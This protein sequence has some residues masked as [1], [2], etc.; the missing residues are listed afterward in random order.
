MSGASAARASGRVTVLYDAFGEAPAL[1]KDWGFAALVE[2]GGERILFDTGNDADIFAH[3]VS[4]LGVELSTIDLVVIS[5]RH[6][7]HTSG[8]NHLLRVNHRVKI[9]APREGF[10]VFGA[11]L[12]G[13]FY[14]QDASLPRR[15]RYFGGEPPEAIPSGTP[16]RGANFIWLDSLT[17]VA[18]GICVIP[19]VSHTPGT[20]ELREL[21]LALATPQGLALV[22]GC[23]HAGIETIVDASTAI[24]PHV[25][26][27]IV[28][29]SRRCRIP[30]PRTA[31]RARSATRGRRRQTL[32]ARQRSH[33]EE[34]HLRRFRWRE[35]DGDQQITLLAPHAPATAQRVL[36]QER[37]FVAT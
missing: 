29:I 21:T 20:L 34:L 12:P 14:R 16:W 26:I 7:D 30:W 10:G 37:P 4:A 35:R 32:L 13:T 9:Y 33:I 8:L 23:S 17:E 5:H 28:A 6:G 24:G 18:P 25:H 15:M 36:R 27:D 11:G 22:V 19:T 2:Y 1:T 31:E 3:N